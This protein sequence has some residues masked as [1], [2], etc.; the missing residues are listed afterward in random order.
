MS[1]SSL[2]YMLDLYCVQGANRVMLVFDVAYD[3]KFNIYN[4][5]SL[6]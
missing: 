6:S 3:F 5:I 2:F 1:S 4:E